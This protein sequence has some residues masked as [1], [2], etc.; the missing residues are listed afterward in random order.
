[1]LDSL[2]K[3]T[4]ASLLG[5]DTFV[6][7]FKFNLLTMFVFSVNNSLVKNLI[8]MKQVFYYSLKTFNLCNL[9][10]CGDLLGFLIV[11]CARF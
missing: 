10:F 7:K 8:E 6:N 3:Q 1:V 4:Q 11:A 5:T 2:S 9:E